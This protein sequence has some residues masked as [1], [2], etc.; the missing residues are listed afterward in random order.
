MSSIPSKGEGDALFSPN[1]HFSIEAQDL[2]D[3]SAELDRAEQT[4]LLLGFGVEH[5]SPQ[6]RPPHV[7]GRIG[8]SAIRAH[9]SYK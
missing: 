3:T 6:S 7:F 8:K 5:V 9:P 2:A 1:Y 4:T